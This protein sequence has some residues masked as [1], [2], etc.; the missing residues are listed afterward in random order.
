MHHI[1]HT[2]QF[3]VVPNLL[4]HMT[5]FYKPANPQPVCGCYTN[6]RFL[7]L[8]VQEEEP[9]NTGELKPLVSST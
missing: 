3:S 5:M 9:G 6:L 7:L 8:R 4:L 1:F 2:S